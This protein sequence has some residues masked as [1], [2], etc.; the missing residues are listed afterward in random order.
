MQNNRN[1]TKRLAASLRELA[2]LGSSVDLS[3]ADT[4]DGAADIEIEQAGGISESRIFEL[5]NGLTGY[6]LYLVV[7]NQTSRAMYSRDVTL[8]VLWEDSL[9]QWIPDPREMG[10]S[11]SYRFP[12]KGSP[13]FPR[14]QVL[15]HVLLEGRALTPRRPWEGWLL[16][17]G[18][19]MPEQPLRDRQWLDA[20]LAILASNRVEYFETIR[21]CTERLALKPKFALRVKGN[22]FE[23]SDGLPRPSSHSSQFAQG[24]SNLRIDDT[25]SGTAATDK[26]R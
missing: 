15:N 1:C 24:S 4:E 22:L 23:E 11:E 10:N 13:E 20:T 7:T 25:D 26:T 5:P 6:M 9:F 12:G 2:S 21:L 16:A 14:E 17:T 18:R 19:P 3:A 8:R